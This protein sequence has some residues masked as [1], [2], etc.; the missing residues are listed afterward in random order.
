MRFLDYVKNTK[1]FGVCF[2][3]SIVRWIIRSVIGTGLGFVPWVL[4][5]FFGPALGKGNMGIIN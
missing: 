3:S 5:R 4:G 2:G 1:S